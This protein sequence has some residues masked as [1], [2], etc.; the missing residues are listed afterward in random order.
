ML[1]LPGGPL[2]K[3]CTFTA[4]LLGS[5]PGWGIKIPQALWCGRNKTKKARQWCWKVWRFGRKLSTSFYGYLPRSL[6]LSCVTTWVVCLVL[7]LSFRPWLESPRLIR[8]LVPESLPDSSGDLPSWL[9]VGLDAP[10]ASSSS[11]SRQPHLKVFV[12]NMPWLLSWFYSSLKSRSLW[13]LWCW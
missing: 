9:A 11:I 2:V 8:P 12:S 1:G 10:L 7:S 13:W 6:F 4:M 5:I 3:N